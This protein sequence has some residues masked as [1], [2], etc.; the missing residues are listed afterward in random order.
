M[1]TTAAVESAATTGERVRRADPLYHEIA[2]WLDDEATM[3]DSGKTMEWVTTRVAEDVLYRLPVRQ[4]RL[5]D[6]PISQFSEGMF[7][8]DENYTTLM[9]K[10]MRLATTASPW[11]ENPLSRTRRFIANVD[12]HRTANDAELEVSCSLLVTRSRYTEEVPQILSGQRK[13]LLRR[14]EGGWQLARRYFYVDQATLGY[15]NLAIFF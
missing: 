10:V 7:H 3:M 9:M 4:N 5:R 12:V 11:A 8:Y 13:D 2:E 14:T 1:T 15:S 6:D